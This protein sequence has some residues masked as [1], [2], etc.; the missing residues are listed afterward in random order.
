M[1]YQK[2]TFLLYNPNNGKYTILVSF[3]CAFSYTVLYFSLASRRSAA[4]PA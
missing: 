4:S 1:L 2:S 3:C